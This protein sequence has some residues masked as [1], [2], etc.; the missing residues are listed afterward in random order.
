[1]SMNKK[2]R[3]SLH[4][5]TQVGLVIAIVVLVNFLLLSVNWKI[6]LTQG[7]QYTLAEVSRSTVANLQDPVT[8]KV[9]FSKDVP[10]NM[11]ALK[12]DTLDLVEEYKQAGHGTIT[13]E[14]VDPKSD[15]VAQQEVSS[16]GIPEIQYNVVGNEKFEVSTG[17]AGMAIVHGDAYQAIPVV[18]DT[19]SL[20]YEITAAI[21][22]MSRTEPLTL[23]WLSDHDTE[24]AQQ[25][26]QALNKQYTIT[27]TTL[28]SLDPAI[29]TLVIA[30]PKQLFTEPERYT[31]DQFIMH[32]GSVIF[33]IDGMTVNQE[34]LAATANKTDLDDLIKTY[35]VTVNNNLVADFASPENLTFGTQAGLQVV[36]P[37]PFWPRIVSAGLNPD[38]PIT[39]KIQSV[40]M[41]WPSTL[42]ITVPPETQVT[43]LVRTSPKS[44]VYSDTV[45][46]SPESITVPD[47]KLLQQYTLGVLLSGK[48]TSAFTADALP[49]DVTATDFTGSTANG[50]LAIFGNSQFIA[51]QMLSNGSDNAVLLENTIDALTQDTSLVAIRS[52]SAL[53]RPIDTTL[54]DTQKA[55]IKYGNIFS[56]IGI[57]VLLAGGAYFMRRRRDFKAQQHYA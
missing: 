24:T 5:T 37:Y 56:G 12:Q 2:R 57:V 27:P 44:Y 18:S 32:G 51:D 50:H 28:A 43:E 52:R 16:Y 10:Q 19:N 38:N 36:R 35:G 42:T 55:T 8:I 17:Y 41:P 1:M 25:L 15:P 54:T 49:A 13:V 11:L 9:F 23:G 3:Y 47:E 31:L 7:K 29:K 45:N 20:E 34:T 26:Q 33:L 6:D 48:L 30:G 39:A 4:S 53:N 14:A 40:T 21:Q 46:I 22:K